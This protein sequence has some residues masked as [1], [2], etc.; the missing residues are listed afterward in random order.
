MGMGLS[1]NA[2]Q[3]N[4]TVVRFIKV[5]PNGSGTVGSRF[6]KFMKVL[7]GIMVSLERQISLCTVL[8]KVNVRHFQI[9]SRTSVF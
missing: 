9:Y 6:Q 8:N 3:F 2:I 1:Y 4:S 5:R 7:L